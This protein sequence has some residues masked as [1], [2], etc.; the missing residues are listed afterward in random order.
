MG[1]HWATPMGGNR[2][3]KWAAQMGGNGTAHPTAGDTY[4]VTYTAGGA[5][6]TLSGHF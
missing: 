4:S 3:A 6:T 5:S 2:P 1:M